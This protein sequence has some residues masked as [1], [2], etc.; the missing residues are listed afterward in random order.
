M[1]RV[2]VP[3]SALSSADMRIRILDG[4]I[5]LTTFILDA[6]SP[7][8]DVSVRLSGNILVIEVLDGGNGPIMDRIRIEEALLITPDS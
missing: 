2:M 4:E 7:A 5:P 3:R 8:E 1:C 6:S